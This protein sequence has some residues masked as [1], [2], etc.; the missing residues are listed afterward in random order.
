MT[1]TGPAD[2]VM[3]ACRRIAPGRLA[4]ARSG[5]RELGFGWPGFGWPARRES[6]FARAVLPA[7]PSGQPA[8][9]RLA[10]RS[11]RLQS[12]CPLLRS[13][14]VRPARFPHP[15]CPRSPAFVHPLHLYLLRWHTAPLYGW[16]FDPGRD[17]LCI[18][19]SPP[20]WLQLP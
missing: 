14:R 6:A 4:L 13:Q 3:S 2:V 10:G 5:S 19:I 15:P 8:H 7:S 16:S 18:F 1:R 20:R 12:A 9:C 17:M 11:G